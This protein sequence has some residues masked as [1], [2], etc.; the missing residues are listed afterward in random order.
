MNTTVGD[1]VSQCAITGTGVGCPTTVVPGNDGSTSTDFGDFKPC[2]RV[3]EVQACLDNDPNYNYGYCENTAEGTF[4]VCCVGTNT[5]T[6]AGGDSC[7][8][9]LP[10]PPSI[11]K[12]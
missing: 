11:S 10:P 12:G 8:V 2:E 4:D 3:D 5:G 6:Y 1:D 9:T 7:M